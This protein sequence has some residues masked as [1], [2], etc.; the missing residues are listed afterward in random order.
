MVGQL[1]EQTPPDV[2]VFQDL[3]PGNYAV[4]VED[5]YG[6]MD[7]TRFTVVAPDPIEA[8][9]S[10][11]DQN[12]C[13]GEADA[14]IV[15]PNSSLV[16]GTGN[17]N[18][19]VLSPAG[20]P[21]GGGTFTDEG[22]GVSGLV[23]LNGDGTYEVTTTDDN[24]CSRVDTVYVNC[25]EPIEWTVD[26]T[27]VVCAGA[28]DG[29]IVAEASGGSGGELYLT[30]NLSTPVLLSAAADSLPLTASIG[31]LGEYLSGVGV[32]C[33][34]LHFGHGLHHGG[35]ACTDRTFHYKCD[36]FDM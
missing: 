26:W 18:V 13:F 15:I 35:G 7:T 2:I 31:N 11:G 10:I 20:N 33:V 27:D 34:G 32:R 25:P 36:R 29:T 14:S 5:S 16:G 9:P 24:G 19:T 1:V 17:L 8:M 21:M 12:S 23:C 6:C 3:F 28:S 22:F 4:K 30:N